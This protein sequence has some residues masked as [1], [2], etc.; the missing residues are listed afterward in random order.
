MTKR[1]KKLA[2]LLEKKRQMDVEIE[3]LRRD[4]SE[5]E[6]DP[7][8]STAEGSAVEVEHAAT[9]EGEIGTRGSR[10]DTASLAGKTKFSAGPRDNP[11]LFLIPIVNKNYDT[12]SAHISTN[13]TK[14]YHQSDSTVRRNLGILTTWRLSYPTLWQSGLSQLEMRVMGSKL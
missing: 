2:V 9:R 10:C 12:R 5:T 1:E 6:S 3:A 7:D 4:R 11:V 13:P 14:I 8:R